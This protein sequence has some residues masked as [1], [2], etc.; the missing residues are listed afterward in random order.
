MTNPIETDFFVEEGEHKYGPFK[1]ANAVAEFAR[2]AAAM[3]VN[4]A[5]G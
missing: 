5:V 2:S 3:C 1:T 4:I